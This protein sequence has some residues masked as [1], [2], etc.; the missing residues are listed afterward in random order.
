MVNLEKLPLVALDGKPLVHKFY[1]QEKEPCGLMVALP[2]NHYGM[3]GPLLYYPCKVL[4][5]TGW[6]TLALTYSYQSAGSEF[7]PESLPSAV[8]ECQDAIRLILSKREYEHIAVIGKSLGAFI[9]AQLCGIEETLEAARCLYITPP[10]GTPIFD[11]MVHENS[12]PAH[13]A[14]G[15]KDR[16]YNVQALA[17]L[18]TKR[19]FGLTLIENAD[20]SMDVAGDLMASI[21]A[22]RRVTQEGIAFILGVE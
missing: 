8:R 4:Q 10:L 22:V 7:S 17:S 19:S 9:I 21:E 11:Q 6:D 1:R 2:G 16:F 15:T 13:I 20:H 18:Q 3:D 5:D 12:Q 14:I